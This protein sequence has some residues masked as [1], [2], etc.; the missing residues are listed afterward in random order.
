M[1]LNIFTLLS[2]VSHVDI[3]NFVPGVVRT[4][5]PNIYGSNVHDHSQVPNNYS[6][7]LSRPRQSLPYVGA[8]SGYFISIIILICC[9]V[10]EKSLFKCCRTHPA[11]KLDVSCKCLRSPDGLLQ[12]WKFLFV[13]ILHVVEPSSGLAYNLQ[14]Q[15]T[16]LHFII[17][18]VL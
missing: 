10:R 3:L 16:S 9:T 13:M 7:A 12:L 1:D 18:R 17:S 5:T 14:G 2:E 11:I 6:I 4:I 8:T 15:L